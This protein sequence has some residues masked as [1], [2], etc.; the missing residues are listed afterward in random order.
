MTKEQLAQMIDHTYLK[1][2]G[3]D[4]AIKR[5]CYEAMFH[6]F[7]SVAVLPTTIP[8]AA[9]ILKG[10]PVKVD[11]ALS[12]FRGRYPL[13]LKMFEV[14]DAIKNGAEELDIVI[15]VDLLK[16]KKYDLLEREF[17]EFV[18]V[19]DG[20][21]TKVILETCLLTD[22]E[23]VA[24]CKIAKETGVSFVKT[25]TGLKGGATVHDVE[26]MRKTVGDSCGVKASGGIRNWEQAKDLIRAGAN[27]L[28]ASAGIAIL[29][30][31]VKEQG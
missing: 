24:A 7:A 18:K 6:N 12:F 31:F 25:S 10:S 14:K 9:K 15:S 19:A 27:R 17:S 8:L 16:E 26:L 28:G 30:G 3:S 21:T 1:M 4:D 23:K 2:G 5:V 29:E 13:E 20:L 22:E 11:A